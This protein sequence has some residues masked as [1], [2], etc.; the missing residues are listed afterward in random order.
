MS[1]ATLVQGEGITDKLYDLITKASSAFPGASDLLHVGLIGMVPYLAGKTA[2]QIL[3]KRIP[4]FE[5]YSTHIG[6]GSA[7]L[8]EFL[9]QGILEPASPYDHPTDIVSDYKGMV[10]IGIGAGLAYL[11][12]RKRKEK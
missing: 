6:F 7:A 12:S 1:L 8:A 10:E 11:L 2:A 3:G 9:W 4:F 5:K